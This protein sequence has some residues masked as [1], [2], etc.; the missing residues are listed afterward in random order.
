[1]SGSSRIQR[2]ER[3]IEIV[4]KETP[5]E[6]LPFSWKVNKNTNF[7]F[8]NVNKFEN[9]SYS[10]L[11]LH[12]FQL[13]GLVH[14]WNQVNLWSDEKRAPTLP[15]SMRLILELGL[16]ANINCERPFLNFSCY[17]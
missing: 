8:S 9:E 1:M 17:E 11:S 14:E 5:S 15:F 10:I 4:G 13:N 12:I 6:W 2:G 7:L 16:F 3:D